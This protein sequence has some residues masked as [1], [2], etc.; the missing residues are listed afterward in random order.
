VLLGTPGFFVQDL[1]RY[2]EATRE[3][4]RAAAARHL[5]GASRVVLS[6]V[7]RGRRDL[8]IAGAETVSVS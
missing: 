1:D 8:A 4:V 5:V 2:R 6:V 3:S 7:P